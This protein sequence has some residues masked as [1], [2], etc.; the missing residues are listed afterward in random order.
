MRRNYSKSKTKANR[1]RWTPKWA[2]C[3]KC[4]VILVL[5]KEDCLFRLLSCWMAGMD[6]ALK[7]LIGQKCHNLTGWKKKRAFYKKRPYIFMKPQKHNTLH[8]YLKASW[9]IVSWTKSFHSS[10]LLSY[11]PVLPY[12]SWKGET[13]ILTLGFLFFFIKS[14]FNGRYLGSFLVTFTL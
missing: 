9:L 14:T 4:G 8:F 7:P 11:F 13:A 5:S 1:K 12:I 3:D 6:F 2:S 10:L